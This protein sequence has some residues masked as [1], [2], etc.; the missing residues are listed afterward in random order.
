M[1]WY[2]W[3]MGTVV[4]LLVMLFLAL[5]TGILFAKGDLWNAALC[6]GA[7][8]AIFI[9]LTQNFAFWYDYTKRI[10]SRKSK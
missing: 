4:P 6:F 1:S 8:T 2:T 3:L 9:A 7:L 10:L 5:S